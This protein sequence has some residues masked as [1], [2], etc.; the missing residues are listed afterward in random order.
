MSVTD[1]L[2]PKCHAWHG[3]EEM[4]SGSGA[5]VRKGRRPIDPLP[6]TRHSL[7]LK[8]TA[9]TKEKL[10]AAAQ[11]SGRTMSQEAERL[12]ELGI[13]FETLLRLSDERRAAGAL[14]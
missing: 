1:G 6:G 3:P 9:E 2:C 7:G 5:G 10:L 14:E 13:I 11:L 4:C 12:M 8:V